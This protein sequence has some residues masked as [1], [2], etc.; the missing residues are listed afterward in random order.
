MNSYA[1]VSYRRSD[2]AQTPVRCTFSCGC[3]TLELRDEHWDRDVQHLCRI[4]S[5]THGFLEVVATTPT[6]ATNCGVR[7]AS[8]R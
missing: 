6:R 7:S 5:G 4:L 3:Q 2:S 8:S 1:F